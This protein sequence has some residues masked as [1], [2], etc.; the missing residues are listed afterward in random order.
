MGSLHGDLKTQIY[1][2]KNNKTMFFT[3]VTEKKTNFMG[4]PQIKITTTIN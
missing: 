2:N 1:T 4:N 3:T